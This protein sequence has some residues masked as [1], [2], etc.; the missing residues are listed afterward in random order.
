MDMREMAEGMKIL[1]NFYEKKLPSTK[2]LDL[3]FNKLQWVNARHYAQAID[4]I[5]TEESKLPTPG[6][7]LKYVDRVRSR[8]AARTQSNDR[9]QN[10]GA[11]SPERQSSQIGKDCCKFISDLLNKWFE[12]EDKLM[13]W[14]YKQLKELHS[15]YPNAGF[16][17]QSQE[18]VKEMNRI[19]DERYKEAV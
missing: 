7:V 12:S 11:L 4:E 13:E 9:W 17:K 14:K 8:E 16:D 5:T 18:L 3:W 6:V 15:K 19:L 10:V 1:C 2:G